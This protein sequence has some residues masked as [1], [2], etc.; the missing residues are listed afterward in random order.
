M[1]HKH[2]YDTQGK[3]LCCTQEER[4]YFNAGAKEILKKEH[5][6]EEHDTEDGHDH[7]SIQESR[8]HLF[9]PAIISFSLL[10]IAIFLDHFY[11][12]SWFT[13]WIRVLWY[14]FCLPSCWFAC[15]QR[16]GRKYW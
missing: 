10:I 14:I 9:L 11:P 12:Q 7:S 2:T 8:L 1:Q 6:P 16:S 13:G 15:A 3:Q 4:I 5:H